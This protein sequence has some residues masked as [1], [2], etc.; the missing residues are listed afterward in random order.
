[1]LGSYTLP[2]RNTKPCPN[3]RNLIK[4]LKPGGYL[5]WDELDFHGIHVKTVDASLQ[6]PDLEEVVKTTYSRG[7]QDWTLQLAELSSDEE[8]QEAKLYY[9]GDRIELARANCEQHLLVMDEFAARLA[10]VGNKK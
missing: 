3:L 7:R 4:M 8:L 6:A 9:F 2:L 5:Q 1:M 10:N